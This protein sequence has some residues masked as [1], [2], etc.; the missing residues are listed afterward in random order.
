MEFELN[1]AR[2]YEYAEEERRYKTI[3]GCLTTTP[4]Q[5]C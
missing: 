2:F 3:K 4:N 1:I 5:L